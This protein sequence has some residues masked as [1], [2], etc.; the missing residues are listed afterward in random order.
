MRPIPMTIIGTRPHSAAPDPRHTTSRGRR[1]SPATS[2]SIT[3]AP[4]TAAIV[5]AVAVLL[6]CAGPVACRASPAGA[7]TGGGHRAPLPPTPVVVTAFS[8]GEHRWSPGHRGV[9]LSA[10]AGT[11]VMAS[12][13]GTVR[14]A[15][16]VA[17]RPVLSILHPDGLITTYEPVLATVRQGQ[18]VSRGQVIGIVEPGHPSCPTMTCLHWGARLGSGNSAAYLDPL[19]LLGAVRVRLKPV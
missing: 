14:H 7:S 18:R 2:T 9:D 1:T 8:V 16:E 19:G 13:A 6:S 4:T 5:T 11:E 17:G 10:R 12:A 3:S 15:G